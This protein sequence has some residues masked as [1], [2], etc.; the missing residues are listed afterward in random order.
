M[1]IM[2]NNQPWLGNA[3]IVQPD[4]RTTNG[5]IHV[6]ASWPTTD[7]SLNET[8]VLGAAK[9]GDFGPFNSTKVQTPS[10]TVRLDNLQFGRL[11][12]RLCTTCFCDSEAAMR[13][14]VQL[15]NAH[16]ICT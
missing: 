10:P 7:L 13:N 1:S 8:T 16:T 6:L 14:F 15:G 12:L 5:I 3:P 9:L 11:S 4:I 2:R